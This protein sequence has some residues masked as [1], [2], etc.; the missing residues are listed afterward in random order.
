MVPPVMAI[1]IVVHSRVSPP[2]R[3]GE[4]SRWMFTTCSGAGR[5]PSKLREDMIGI[6]K[7]VKWELQIVLGRKFGRDI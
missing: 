3:A 5:G 2:R 6:G 4:S 1:Y 7:D